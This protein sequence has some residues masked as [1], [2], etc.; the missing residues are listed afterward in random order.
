M[1]IPLTR[2]RALD[3]G[4][5]VS[6]AFAIFAALALAGCASFDGAVNTLF[7][8]NPVDVWERRELAKCPDVACRRHV[9]TLAE[10]KRVRQSADWAAI[11]AG[12]NRRDGQ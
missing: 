1:T 12:R 3:L 6:L 2:K 9:Q 4:A 7:G 11:E 8:P 10:L 5:A